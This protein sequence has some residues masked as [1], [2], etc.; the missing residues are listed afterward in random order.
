MDR[1][2]NN[3]QG[4]VITVRYDL[5]SKTFTINNATVDTFFYP[6]TDDGTIIKTE[7]VSWD[8]WFVSDPEMQLE[9][10]NWYFSAMGPKQ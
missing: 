1:V 9:I 2:F 10:G 8:D 5:P 6:M 4:Q 3:S 7:G